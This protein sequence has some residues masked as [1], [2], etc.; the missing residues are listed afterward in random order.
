MEATQVGQ[1]QLTFLSGSIYWSGV[2]PNGSTTWFLAS[3]KKS[4]FSR[5]YGNYGSG[6]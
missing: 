1:F 5:F 6:F 4:G 3:G 2:E